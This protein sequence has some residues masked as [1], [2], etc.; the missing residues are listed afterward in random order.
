MGQQSHICLQRQQSVGSAC[1]IQE[2]EDMCTTSKS[3]GEIPQAPS[4][5]AELSFSLSNPNVYVVI[6]QR[7]KR[8]QQQQQQSARLACFVVHKACSSTTPQAAA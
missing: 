6:W 1:V 7:H 3:A 2:H 5:A 8:L 4:S